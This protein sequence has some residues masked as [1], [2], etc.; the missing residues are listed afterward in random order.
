MSPLAT[1]RS[2]GL[3]IPLESKTISPASSVVSP[4]AEIEFRSIRVPVDAMSSRPPNRLCDDERPLRRLSFAL[5]DEY[6][7][8][9]LPDRAVLDRDPVVA[10]RVV[11]A[12]ITDI[13]VGAPE[14]AV[15]VDRVAVQVEL[16]V[17]GADHDAVARAVDQV[18]LSFV[19]LVIV[20]PQRTR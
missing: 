13:L 3:Q 11:D 8:R 17:V 6:A 9:K 19:S 4:F 7:G 12:E 14:H 20:S 15:A 10:G 18:D 16:D 5:G 2:S 1:T